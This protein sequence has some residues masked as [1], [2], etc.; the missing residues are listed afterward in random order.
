MKF[1]D[2][3][4]E[5][6]VSPDTDTYEYDL[7]KNAWLSAQIAVLEDAMCEDIK[8]HTYASKLQYDMVNKESR[9]IGIKN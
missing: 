2:W 4:L 6:G 1:E 8:S 3:A 9:K 7:C 5:H